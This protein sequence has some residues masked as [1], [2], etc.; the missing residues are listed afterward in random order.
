MKDKR[1]AAKVNREEIRQGAERTR[2]DFDEHVEFVI[3]SLVPIA[4]QPWVK[5]IIWLEAHTHNSNTKTSVQ[6]I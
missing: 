3:K 4:P 5:F 1:F 2:V 6:K